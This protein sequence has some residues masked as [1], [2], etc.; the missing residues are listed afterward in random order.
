MRVAP[1]AAVRYRREVVVAGVPNRGGSERGAGE[2][3]G[4][5]WRGDEGRAVRDDA[6]AMIGREIDGH[7]LESVL[8]EGGTGIV[9]RAVHTARGDEIAVKVLQNKHRPDGNAAARFLRESTLEDLKHDNI[10]DVR[11]A[12]FLPDGRPYLTMELLEGEALDVRIEREGRLPIGE[13]IR[14]GGD[15]LDGLAAAHRAGVVHRDVKPANVFLARQGDSTVAKLLDFSV[16]RVS[17]AHSATVTA[18][19]D[20]VGTPLYL[21]PEQATG[22][23][24]LD[25]RIDLWA[26]GVLLYVLLTGSPP[27]AAKQLAE[28]ILKVVSEEP[29]RPSELREDIPTALSDVVMKALRK[30]REE[31][32]GS[33]EEMAAALRAVDLVG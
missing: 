1:G 13:S 29:L 5:V 26:V 17:D 8:G 10:V 20:I 23:K 24:G 33:A 7:R 25:G 3:E 4:S 31:R 2:A 27:F 6:R 28:L 22:I 9:F 19:G 11:S 18:S 12:G 32:F 16:A 21:A 30:P 15:V 14:I